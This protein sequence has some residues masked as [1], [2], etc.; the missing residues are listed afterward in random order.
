MSDRASD[1]VRVFVNGRGVDVARGA[2][3][4][5]AVHAADAREGERVDAGERVIVDSRG[6]PLDATTGA[7]AGAIYRTVSARQAAASDDTA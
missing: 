6:L 7:Y 2:H 4:R 3:A 5:A 1:V